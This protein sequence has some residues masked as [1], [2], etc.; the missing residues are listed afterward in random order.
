MA[1][2]IRFQLR[3][4]TAE[5]WA[6]KNPKLLK[7]EPGYDMTNNRLKLG[8][9]IDSWN[10]LPYLKT[11]SS[12][13]MVKIIYEDGVEATLNWPSAG[14]VI[15]NDNQGDNTQDNPTD[16]NTDNNNDTQDD[17]QGNEQVVT[18]D[19]GDNE[20]NEGETPVENSDDEPNDEPNEENT[21]ITGGE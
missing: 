20:G 15:P 11:D 4:D 7:N 12:S 6:N 8:N 1:T 17:N 16:D 2:S 3:G 13:K 5:N 18:P 10:D 21:D 9:G 14:E 19:D